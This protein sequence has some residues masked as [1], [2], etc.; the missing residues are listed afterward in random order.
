VQEVLARAHL[1]WSRVS[2]MHA[3]EAYL[4][5]A[6][7]REFLSWRR[8]RASTEAVLADL[9]DRAD[10]PD[11]AARTADRDQMWKLLAGLT[12]GQRAVL[13]L[14]FYCD[15]PDD[16]IAEVLGWARPTVRSQASRALARLRAE[17]DAGAPRE[18]HHG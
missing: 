16:E 1:R 18:A 14:R 9:P 8:R 17:L 3:P 2:R 12:G 4:R 6:I 7:T 15:L 13:V 5:T 11:L 10:L